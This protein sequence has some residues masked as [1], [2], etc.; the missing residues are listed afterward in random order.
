MK[1]IIYKIFTLKG[2]ML[3]TTLV[4]LYILSEHIKIMFFD[5]TGVNNINTYSN[6][7]SISIKNRFLIKMFIS[8]ILTVIN[9][10]VLK[11]GILDVLFNYKID[12]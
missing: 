11:K 6:M 12:H 10:I 9:S 2:L 7:G 5:H 8:M 3:T 4:V 1:E